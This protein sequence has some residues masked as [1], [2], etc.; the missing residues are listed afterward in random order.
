MWYYLLSVNNWLM[1]FIAVA[2]DFIDVPSR[3]NRS[4]ESLLFIGRVGL[5]FVL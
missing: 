5:E 1:S 3:A 2:A 4:L